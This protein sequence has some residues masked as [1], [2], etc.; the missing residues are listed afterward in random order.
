MIRFPKK[1][2][3]VRLEGRTPVKIYQE[4]KNNQEQETKYK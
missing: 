3:S 2:M 4:K 1:I